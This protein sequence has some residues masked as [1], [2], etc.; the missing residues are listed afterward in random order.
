MDVHRG[1]GAERVLP[2]A[3]NVA[4]WKSG[5][6]LVL[7]DVLEFDLVVKGDQQ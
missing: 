2:Q 3:C 7:G 4:T 1:I 5:D 6:Q